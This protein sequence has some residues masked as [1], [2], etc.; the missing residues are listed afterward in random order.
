[1][2][3]IFYFNVIII[4]NDFM[5]IWLGAA[6]QSGQILHLWS[7]GNLLSLH[8]CPYYKLFLTIPHYSVD[9]LTYPKQCSHSGSNQRHPVKFL[10]RP[11]YLPTSF[12]LNC[13]CELLYLPSTGQ[14]AGVVFT[15]DFTIIVTIH[16]KRS[17]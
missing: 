2:W 7:N 9:L 17:L 11:H 5:C 12:G 1:M 4:F 3:F 13:W 15:I 10:R 6:L 8:L 14:K 16:M